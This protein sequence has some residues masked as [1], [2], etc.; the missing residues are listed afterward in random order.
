MDSDNH[1]SHVVKERKKMKL[2]EAAD[3]DK[4]KTGPPL[5][6]VTLGELL[7][8]RDNLYRFMQTEESIVRRFNDDTTIFLTHES[9][10]LGWS[11]KMTLTGRHTEGR[12]MATAERLEN[13]A[14]SR[15]AK[16]F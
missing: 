8:F 2:S 3:S 1:N 11:I 10:G 5:R 16:G 9:G 6:T 15:D 14:E 4:E 7:R 12:N 13:P